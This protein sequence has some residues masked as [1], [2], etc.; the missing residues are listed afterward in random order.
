MYSSEHRKHS[1]NFGSLLSCADS[2]LSFISA[3]T[4]IRYARLSLAA[5][6]GN[7]LLQI[8]HLF[9]SIFTSLS[10]GISGSGGRFLYFLVNSCL[11]Q[12]INFFIKMPSRSS[13]YLVYLQTLSC[14]RAAIVHN[15]K[16]VKSGIFILILN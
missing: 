7:S 10:G 11:S 12:S 8:S 4:S 15:K 5:V 1:N 16:N 3:N 13:I 9:T 2:K 6:S 14:I